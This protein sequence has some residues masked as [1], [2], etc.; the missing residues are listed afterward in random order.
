LFDSQL[1][2]LASL[3]T[4][5]LWAC[6]SLLFTLGSKRIG[7]TV[8]N[9]T[10]LIFALLFISTFHFYQ[11]GRVIPWETE[12]WR[13]GWLGV[14]SILGLVIGDGALFF[15]FMRI[16][17]QLSMLVMTLVPVICTFFAWL[18]F[19]ESIRPLEYVGIGVTV[20]AIGWVVSEQRTA[21]NQEEEADNTAVEGE[22]QTNGL[23]QAAERKNF[24]IGIGLAFVGVLGQT[25]NVIMTKVALEGDYSELSATL[26]RVLVAV[27]CLV[28]WTVL[29]GNL[30]ATLRKYKDVRALCYVASG[31]FVGPFLGIWFSYI[32]IEN[33]RVGIATT[34]MATP[35]LLL[36]P[37]GAI[38]L[39]DR[40]TIRAFV[41]TVLAIVGVSI[42]F[43][44]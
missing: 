40:V 6:C 22:A 13:W 9:T 38:F 7:A 14:S 1:G 30:L 12:P 43:L 42:L 2:E 5:F 44:K 11:F 21:P 8:V 20:L 35:P 28:L 19:G 37:L 16:G 39:S 15:A 25:A 18:M 29:T 24:W 31:A 3:A 36:L 10:R 17:P 26:C 41:G 34:I 32:A 33:T 4:A 23:D 27:V